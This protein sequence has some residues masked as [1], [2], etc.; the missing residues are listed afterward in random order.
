MPLATHDELPTLLA[1]LESPQVSELYE[2]FKA[3]NTPS[4][5]GGSSPGATLGPEKIT[6]VAGAA[7]GGTLSALAAGRP[8]TVQG[9]FLFDYVEHQKRLKVLTQAQLR[10]SLVG[11]APQGVASGIGRPRPPQ[12]GLASEVGGAVLG[13]AIG[14]IVETVHGGGIPATLLV[15]LLS[16]MA[17][18]VLTR[19]AA[20]G[21]VTPK[22]SW[23]P[24]S[25][26]LSL[27]LGAGG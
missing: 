21:V 3:K 6:A 12:T 19:M 11:S 2:Q 25:G 17:G 22:F 9:E 16:A 18:A 15:S 13:G 20:D 7:L 4:A 10:P 5:S 1:F 8:V 26:D 24:A 27:E 14:G 23:N